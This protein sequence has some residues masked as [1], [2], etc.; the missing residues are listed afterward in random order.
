MDYYNASEVISTLEIE[1]NKIYSNGG[2]SS[3]VNFSVALP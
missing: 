2:L 3:M 1:R